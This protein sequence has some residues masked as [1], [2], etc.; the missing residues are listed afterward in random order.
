MAESA[1]GV[2]SRVTQDAGR[3]ADPA[4]SPD[5]RF[6]AFKKMGSGVFRKDLLT[7]TE[8]VVS[9]DSNMSIDDWTADGKFLIAKDGSPVIA[10][11]AFGQGSPIRLPQSTEIDETHVSNDGRWVAYNSDESG[12][13]EV[14]VASFPEFAG[15]QQVSV[16]GGLQPNWRRDGRELFFVTPD[17]EMM[18]VA[19]S[20]VPTLRIDTP[21]RLFTTNLVPTPGWSQYSVT[22]DG[23]RFLVMEST[24]QFFTVLQHWLPAKAGT[25]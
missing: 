25:Q 12:E 21:K 2:F 1:K 20:T 17:G 14:Y 13:W 11:P 7:G 23:Q 8:T 9:A 3:E 19:I 22:P 5:E 15:K 16:A 18:S 6:L 4:W 24:R 10:V